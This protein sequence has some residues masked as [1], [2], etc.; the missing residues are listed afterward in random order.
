MLDKTDNFDTSLNEWIVEVPTYTG[1]SA[2]DSFAVSFISD[3]VFTESIL[4]GI[5]IEFLPAASAS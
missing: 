1:Y 2:V 5:T 3:S 4:N